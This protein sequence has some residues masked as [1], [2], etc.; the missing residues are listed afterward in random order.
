MDR[1][2]YLLDRPKRLLAAAV[3]PLSI[4]LL[5]AP[6][7][8]SAFAQEALENG[9]VEPMGHWVEFQHVQFENIPILLHLRTGYERAVLMPEPV[10]LKDANLTLPGSEVLIDQEVVGFYPTTS[11]TRRSMHFI[12]LTTGTVYE[13]RISA[14]PTGL[15]QPLQINR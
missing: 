9:E 6:L 11:F 3:L 13:L 15:R 10:Q 5:T 14:S 2:S 1:H 8:S 4:A 12:G 7:C